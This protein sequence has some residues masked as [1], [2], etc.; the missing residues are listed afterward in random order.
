MVSKVASERPDLEASLPKSFGF[1]IGIEFRDSFLSLSPKC[2]RVLKS[3]MIF[4]LAVSFA[5]I[6]DP[7]DSSKTYSLQLIDTI[8]VGKSSSS[9][10]ADGLKELKEVAFFFN[11]KPKNSSKSKASGSRATG[12]NKDVSPTKKNGSPRKS[13]AAIV[14]TSRK[15]RLRNDGKEIDNEATAKRKIHQKELSERR[16]EEGLAKFAEDDGT[17]RGSVVK[18]WKRFES[19]QRERDLP[20]S[21]SNL[22]IT[23]EINKRSF[24]LPINGFAVPFHINTL[25]SVVKQEEGEYT[26]L[27]FMFIA[28]GQITGKKEDTPFEDPNATFIRGLTYRSTD[29][30][31]MND[32]HKQ[33]TELKKAVLKREKDQAEKAEVVDQDQLIEFRSKRPVKMLDISVRPS[34][35]GKRQAGDVEIH[36]NGLR[37]QSSLK[38]DHRIGTS[39][40]SSRFNGFVGSK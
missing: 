31:H 30:E 28:P 2:S 34:F 32:V 13:G 40:S 22:R 19:F 12:K 33:V 21:V 1:G 39:Y 35:D 24:I 17:G 5:N 27:R 29:Q 6:E 7:F 23:V 11:D 26:V 4:S 18:Q 36:Q 10:L 9:I 14:T 15:G 25:K 16:Q 20:N 3:N 37:Y 8:S 38:S